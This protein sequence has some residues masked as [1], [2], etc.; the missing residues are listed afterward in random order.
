MHGLSG[1]ALRGWTSATLAIAPALIALATT[2]SRAQPAVWHVHAVHRGDSLG[3]IARS[4]YGSTRYVT[5]LRVYNN[6]SFTMNETLPQGLWV[7]LPSAWVHTAAP[8]DSWNSLALLYYRDAGRAFVLQEANPQVARA[9]PT[10]GDR[11]LIPLPQPLEIDE[12]RV[13]IADIAESYLDDRSQRSALLQFNGLR[14][15]VLKRGAT[16]LV[17]RTDAVLRRSQDRRL[18]QGVLSEYRRRRR[19]LQRQSLRARLQ[20]L[21]SATK[22]GLFL[23]VVALG[24]ELL[25]S[26]LLSPAEQASVLLELGHA[27]LAFDR[28]AESLRMVRRAFRAQATARIASHLDSPK[29][30]QLAD[31]ARQEAIQ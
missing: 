29:F 24:H 14:R 27:Y 12:K 20:E 21:S 17:P 16:L 9:G 4:Y 22:S 25:G 8:S 6:L 31:T 23:R 5:L 10:P 7:V 3:S 15:S 28:T 11:V 19:Q 2:T 13:S 26:E 1:H 30:R 18:E